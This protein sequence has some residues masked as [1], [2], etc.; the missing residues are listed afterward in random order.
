MSDLDRFVNFAASV[1]TTEDGS[2]LVIEPFQRAMLTEHFAGV[3]E[4]VCITPKKLGK[5]SLLA[6]RGLF[7]LITVPD[8]TGKSSPPPATRPD[9]FSSRR[10]AISAALPPSD[11]GSR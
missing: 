2:P 6:G 7:E 3:R 8:A 1:L 11:A 10:P 4:L 5:S 9:S